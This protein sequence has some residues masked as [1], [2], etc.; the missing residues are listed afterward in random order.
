M[1]KGNTATEIQLAILVLSWI[2]AAKMS[3][4][5][6]VRIAGVC[7]TI[8]IQPRGLW[9]R[10]AAGSIACQRRNLAEASPDNYTE[11]H[12]SQWMVTRKNEAT[13]TYIRHCQKGPP[14]STVAG[15]IRANRVQTFLQV[16]LL[17]S[18]KRGKCGRCDLGRI[19]HILA[20]G[21]R[22]ACRN[23]SRLEAP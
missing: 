18:L 5:P 7:C 1:Q 14:G 23:D 8:T 19:S 6:V 21:L 17:N 10:K 22:C 2:S 20:R 3:E 13:T 9:T 11:S 4:W 15:M 12:H 16:S